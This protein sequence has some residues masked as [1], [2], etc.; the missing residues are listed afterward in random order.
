MVKAFQLFY[1]IILAV[2]V[3]F[4]FCLSKLLQDAKTEAVKVVEKKPTKPEKAPEAEPK[5][6]AKVEAEPKVSL[7]KKITNPRL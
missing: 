3:K 7:L 2:S 6:V 1:P 4:N 5:M